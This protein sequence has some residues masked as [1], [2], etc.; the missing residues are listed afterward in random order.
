MFAQFGR[1]LA[2]AAEFQF[3]KTVKPA[4]EARAQGLT[5]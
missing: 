4:V 1:A 3:E 5:G 2:K